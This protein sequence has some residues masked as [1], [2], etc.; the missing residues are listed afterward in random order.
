MMIV[1]VCFFFSSR[2]RHTSCALGTGVQTCA[3][4]IS[5]DDE[6]EQPA[7]TQQDALVAPRLDRG[8]RDGQAPPRATGP[9]SEQPRPGPVELSL[10]GPGEEGEHADD[11]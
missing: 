10:G 3:L 5:G 8:G 11:A 1:V 7:T 9:E 4:P 6:H 2:R